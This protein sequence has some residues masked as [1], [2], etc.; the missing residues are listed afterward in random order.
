VTSPHSAIATTAIDPG[1]AY[2][3]SL[4]ESLHR[5]AAAAGGLV[6]HDLD[7]AGIRVRLRFAGND[8]RDV[9]MPP[10]EHLTADGR[11]DPELSI[12]VFDSASTGVT[13]APFPW[14]VPDLGPA[15]NPILR[16][17]SDRA[18]V[19]AENGMGALSAA[20]LSTGEAVLQLA[21]VAALLHG[22]RA[23]PLRDAMQLLLG[24]RRRWL[25]HAAAAGHD[26]IGALLVGHSGSGKS[27]LA[28][29]CA[30]AGMEV[31]SDDYVVLE[32]GAPPIAHA[33]Q[34]TAKVSEDSADRLRLPDAVLDGAGFE[35]TP[36][37]PAKAVVD[38][39]AAA[40]GRMRR[41]LAVGAVIAP[42]VS[43]LPRPVL[44]PIS[45]AHGLRALAPSTIVQARSGRGELL[46]VL[47]GLVRKVPS[48]SLQLGPEP[49]ANA[50][51]VAGVVDG[52][53]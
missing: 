53:A 8:A 21:D 17:R 20:D 13:P 9:L 4:R 39:R 31:V 26:G 51:A 22:E 37:G 43:D 16:Y 45:A 42:V 2:L 34:S 1:L 12:G 52:L 18:C 46:A 14:S 25:T 6:E 32:M 27:T 10:Y 11:G 3:D 7:L 24:G 30:L 35:P 28:L 40:P 15:T 33:M 36:E 38:L 49:S 29:S 44:E 19:V 48:Y 50:E 47:G 41:R 5:A 23:V